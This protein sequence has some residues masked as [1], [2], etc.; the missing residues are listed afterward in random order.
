[1]FTDIW[2]QLYPE[3]WGQEADAV[4]FGLKWITD[5]AAS[6]KTLNKPVILEEFGVT[7]AKFDQVAVYTKWLDAVISSGLSGELIWQAGSK[8]G[9][10]TS[11]DDGYTYY[12]G[13]GVYALLQKY[14]ATIKARA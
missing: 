2:I 3:S 6:Q 5:H 11:Y 9:G 13:D 7:K 8:L 4:N 1:M 12:P 14:S 10:Y